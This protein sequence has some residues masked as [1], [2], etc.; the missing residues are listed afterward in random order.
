MNAL[1]TVFL[2]RP[3]IRPFLAL[4]ALAATAALDSGCGD[5]RAPDPAPPAYPVQSAP[6]FRGIEDL[7]RESGAGLDAGRPAALRDSSLIVGAVA[8]DYYDDFYARR[9]EETAVFRMALMVHCADGSKVG[10]FFEGIPLTQAEFPQIVGCGNAKLRAPRL[11]KFLLADDPPEETS[12]FRD[13]FWYDST[14]RFA[15]SF[16]ELMEK[17]FMLTFREFRWHAYFLRD[18]PAGVAF[19]CFQTGFDGNRVTQF[20]LFVDLKPELGH[21]VRLDLRAGL[22]VCGDL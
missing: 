22:E 9:G 1:G 14:R 21:I 15:E 8:L 10:D 7:L 3:A 4:A 20:P 6:G 5:S 16:P 2:L 13:R 19:I 11:H 17:D 18:V 12:P